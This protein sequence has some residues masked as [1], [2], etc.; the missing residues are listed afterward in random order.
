MRNKNLSYLL[1]INLLSIWIFA[2][3]VE[4][5]LRSA[6][7]TGLKNNKTIL[8]PR[9]VS[10]IQSVVEYKINRAEYK[11]RITLIGESTSSSSMLKL[12]VSETLLPYLGTTLTFGIDKFFVYTTDESNL[13]VTFSQ[14]LSLSTILPSFLTEKSLK[15]NYQQ[16]HFE[17]K[18][19]RQNLIVEIISSYMSLLKTMR[20]FRR[21]EELLRSTEEMKNVIEVK[22]KSGLVAEVELDS[23]KLQYNLDLN[24]F[25]QQK[26]ELR[27]Q[28]EEFN[29][30]LGL[31]SEVEVVLDE[32]VS[33]IRSTFSFDECLKI[34]MKNNPEIKNAEFQKYVAKITLMSVQHMRFPQ[35]W[36]EGSYKSFLQLP[37]SSVQER[38]NLNVLFKLNWPLYS[39]GIYKYRYTQA[40]NNLRL[41]EHNVEDIK[42]KVEKELR[43]I[44]FQMELNKRQVLSM[45]ESKRMAEN[46]LKVA[47][48]KLKNG[49]ISYQDWQF[50]VDK[51]KQAD[52]A[53][54]DAQVEE[55][56][57]YVKLLRAMGICEEEVLWK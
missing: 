22:V 31:K 50:T 29:R 10:Y 37:G 45:K 51:Y 15:F 14:P 32:N 46:M 26:E 17:Y 35:L 8:L 18:L 20:N 47:E 27:R 19:A 11:P 1:M 5:N 43:D 42:Y 44:F 41:A 38:E 33:I 54:Y 16:S 30:L 4:L 36:V 52:Q 56:L 3:V 13:Y 2:E 53:Y 24:E 25:E 49:M 23:M 7:F 57:L 40:K 12:N 6:V 34:A 28:K 55:L 9:E 39:G 21:A 48:I